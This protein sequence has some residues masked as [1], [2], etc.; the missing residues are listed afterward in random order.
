MKILH[1]KTYLLASRLV[2]LSWFLGFVSIT[3]GASISDN[4]WIDVNSNGVFNVGDAPLAQAEVKLYLDKNEDGFPERLL[5]RQTVA[6]DGRFSFTD[7]APGDYS[8]GISLESLPERYY[9]PTTLNAGAEEIDNDLDPNIL[10]TAV[11]EVQDMNEDI[12]NRASIGMLPGSTNVTYHGRIDYTGFAWQSIGVN[13]HDAWTYQDILFVALPDKGLDT[14]KVT[15]WLK[16]YKRVDQLYQQMLLLPNYQTRCRSANEDGIRDKRV[17]AMVQDSCGAGCGNGR[18]AEAVGII[19]AA[20]AEPEL[21]NYHWILFYEMSRGLQSPWDGK[22]VWPPR[23]VILPHFMGALSFYEFGGGLEG[24]DRASFRGFSPGGFLPDS[25]KWQTLGLNYADT[26]ADDIDDR[27]VTIDGSTFYGGS[28]ISFVLYKIA[29]EEG[30][31][32]LYEVLKNMGNKETATSSLEAAMNFTESVLDATDGTYADLLSENFG[33]PTPAE[34]QAFRLADSGVLRPSLGINFQRFAETVGRDLPFDGVP[35][36]THTVG[37]DFRNRYVR[38]SDGSVFASVKAPG[39]WQAG[40]ATNTTRDLIY[41]SY[42]NEDERD[43]PEVTISG[44]SDWMSKSGQSSYNVRIY[45]NMDWYSGFKEAEISAGGSVIDRIPFPNESIFGSD[46]GIRAFGDSARLTQD[47]ITIRSSEGSPG[48]GTISGIAIYGS[49][50]PGPFALTS[51][52]DGAV[53]QSTATTF[54]W[55]AHPAATEYIL[56]L[57]TAGAPDVTALVSTNRWVPDNPLATDTDYTWTVLGQN[58]N[59]TWESSTWSFRTR[60]QLA[61][62]QLLSPADNSVSVSRFPQ[63]D[64][65]DVAG[66]E[67]YLVKV[68]S[69]GLSSPEAFVQIANESTFKFPFALKYGTTYRWSI[70]ARNASSTVQS[71]QSWTFTTAQDPC[72]TGAFDDQTE[73]RWDFG[74]AQAALEPG[75]RSFTPCMTNGFMKWVSLP[76]NSGGAIHGGGALQ[77]DPLGQSLIFGFGS[78]EIAHRLASGHWAITVHFSDAY[79]QSGLKVIAEGEEILSN[80]SFP[81]NTRFQQTVQL[82]VTDGELNLVFDDTDASKVITIAGLHLTRLGD[83]L[84]QDRDGLLDTWETL[85]FDN[86]FTQNGQSDTDSDGTPEWQE[87][88][89]EMDPTNPDEHFYLTIQPSENGRYTLEMPSRDGVVFRVMKSPQLN[90]PI[91]DWAWEEVTDNDGNRLGPFFFDVSEQASETRY[92]Y[93]VIPLRRE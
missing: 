50:L 8:V 86:I 36:W 52:V 57:S 29:F 40:N 23:S 76:A 65:T 70:A 91:G 59:A 42:L 93:S 87:F 53:E 33:F 47:T 75:W 71:E 21:W 19:D 20:S 69:V 81:A 7:L 24:L 89:L 39:L 48:R 34:L 60:S 11:I 88:I 15:R 82:D 92:F 14:E 74:P 41:H 25:E 66:T 84:D 3:E 85:Y 32:K 30:Y 17:V 51:P 38:G 10:R 45:R 55:E 54:E 43:I 67:S 27:G 64:W 5:E 28:V 22:S 26:F 12:V 44:L 2:I 56:T 68:Q 90:Q 72:D 62:P 83:A 58:A 79:P 61:S 1:R 46:G 6:P 13:P 4:V 78:G 37:P 18:K 63:F 9:L 49:N 31:E 80:I 16:W 77:N 35:E 73:Y